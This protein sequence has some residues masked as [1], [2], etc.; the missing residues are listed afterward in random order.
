MT[1]LGSIGITADILTPHP[2]HDT[3][4]DHEAVERSFQFYIGWF[5]HPIYSKTGNYP[6]VMIDR[7]KELSEKQ[8]FS[9]SRLPAFTDHEI[10]MIQNTSDFFGM[11]TYT[12]YEVTL[13]DDDKNPAKYPVPSFQHDLG[14]IESWNESWG[15]S[16]S[17]WLRV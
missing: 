2:L 16:G 4:N 10:K 8:G 6:S 11:N 12:S 14:I 5:M 15:K 9:K 17:Y 13:N 3:K 7:I 1:F